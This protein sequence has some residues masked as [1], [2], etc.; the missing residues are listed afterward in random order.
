MKVADYTEF[1][2]L[3][4][5]DLIR[6][7]EISQRE[8][9]EAALNAVAQVNP[10]INAVIETWTD[11]KVT[12]QGNAIFFG[13]PFLIKDVGI[14]MAGRRGEVGSRLAS[15]YTS[16]TDSTLMKQFRQAGFLTIGRTA[17][18]EFAISTTT[19]PVANG[20]TRNP[21]D[22]SRSAGGSSGG[23][24]AAV[25]AGTVPIAHGTDASGS[26]RVPAS[27]NGL[28]GLKPT[29]GRVSNGPFVDEIWSGLGVQFGL[30]RSVR[31]SAALLDVAAGHAFGEPYYTALP[32]E[33]YLSYAE[34][35]PSSLSIGLQL[36]PHNGLQTA[37]VI[38]AAI[39]SIAK[40]C[41]A[42]G[43]RLTDVT[44]DIG[45]SWEAF[46]YANAV[47]CG[48]G[49]AA[50]AGMIASASGREM[51]AKT[52][53]AA[54]LATCAFG[55][56]LTAI[57]YLR[58]LDARNTVTR[59]YATYF[60]NFDVLLTPS[61]A[62]LPPA[63]GSYIDGVE[64]LDGLAYISRVFDHAPFSPLANMAGVPAISLPLSIDTCTGLPI[65]IQ[66][67]A[68]FGREDLLFQLAG[69]LE[70]A[71]PWHQRKPSTWAGDLLMAQ[72][73]ISRRV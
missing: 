30:S 55:R 15:G 41:E 19:E 10:R 8:V 58:A 69:Q 54:T 24:G 62:E 40:I 26:I 52:M 46:V 12:A 49:T 39:R 45:L 47:L 9:A 51:N 33:H 13:V 28:V 50:W 4:L 23:S 7:G 65:G 34:R 43:H 57:D 18:P 71:H 67:T 21:W 27:N 29:R 36:Q 35:D 66:F 53:E 22:L 73:A 25:A 37:P 3:G 48:T 31:D 14:A 59:S 42:L 5:A 2:A 1:D 16:A 44:P 17:T 32:R 56:G 63:I 38:V 6:G 72:P 64:Q 61:L 11:E 70:R 60:E 20:P 68:G